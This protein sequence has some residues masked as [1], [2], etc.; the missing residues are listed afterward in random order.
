MKKSKGKRKYSTSILSRLLVPMLF[1]FVLQAA[2]MMAMFL[3]SDILKKSGENAYGVLSEKVLNRKLIIENEMTNRWTKVSDLHDRV[4]DVVKK[5]L[6]VN[7]IK[8]YDLAAKPEVQNRILDE[9]LPYLL[10]VIRRNYVTGVF[11]VLDAPSP[12]IKNTEFS[13]PGLYIRTD[14]PSSY[15]STNEDIVISRGP[16]DVI[17][18]HKIALGIDWLPF[19]TIAPKSS[20][21]SYRYFNAPIAAALKYPKEPSKNSAFWNTL[22]KLDSLS[23]EVITYSI[24]LMDDKGNIYGVIGID[25][26]AGYIQSFLNFDELDNTKKGMYCMAVRDL[27]GKNRSFDPIVF[28]S[29]ATNLNVDHIPSFEAEKTE[30]AN[31]YTVDKSSIFAERYCLAVEPFHLYQRNGMYE[32]QEWVL[33]GLAPESRILSFSQTLKKIFWQSVLV[34]GFL[35]LAGSYL[36]SKH[37]SSMF[38]KVVHKLQNSDPRKRVTIE[39]MNISE[40]DTLITA[41]EKLSAS[42]FNAASRVSTIIERLQVPIGVFE[43]NILMG[44]VFCNSI[45]FK[46]F[47]IENYTGDSVLKTDEFYKLL[48]HYE[49]YINTKD[50]EKTIYAIPTGTHGMVRWIRFMQ[51]KENDRTLGMAVDITKEVQD[52]KKLELQMNY[53]ELTGLYNRSAFDRKIT[54]VFKQKHLG[55]CALVMWDLDN[56]KYLNDSFGHAYGDTHLMSFGKKLAMLQQDRCLVCRR[57]GDEFYTF[58]YTFSTSDEIKLILT[59]FWKDIQETSIKLPNGENSK[60]RVS[61]GL[62]WYPYDADNQADLVRYAD[63][64]MY[65]VKHSFKGSLHEFNL[66]VYK[67]NYIMIYGTEALNQM[68]E[69]NLIEYAMQPIVIAGT[70][71]IYGYEMLMRS[72]HPDFKNPEDILRLA[73]AQSK[74][75]KLEELTFF[76]AMETFVQKIEKGEISK[77]AKIFLNTISSQVLS[78]A[79]FFD[80]EERFKPYLSNIVMEI[81]ESEPLNTNFYDIKNERIRNWN[82]MIAI[83]DFG[84]GYSNESS[85]LFLSP[86]LVKIDMSI[87]R[88]VHK[89]LDKQNVLE[90]LVSY[91]KKR[92]IIILAEGVETID[93]IDVLLRFGVDLFQGYFFAKPS[94]DIVPISEEKIRELNRIYSLY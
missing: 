18:K 58:F 84:S 64:A 1:V 32:N 68:L 51:M 86:N 54:E 77:H 59:A 80:F 85:L 76:G 35:F 40:I 5:E 67:K 22:F 31:V 56:L 57:S 42:V 88:D 81:T 78:D 61:A 94:F 15:S 69:R 37:I 30:Y 62:A 8:I 23:D 53:D 24:P 28:N 29:I 74:L 34:S 36:S 66:D 79:K 9:V 91:A 13:Y 55:I 20:D 47:N 17:Q 52:R 41:I 87:V 14:A 93:E 70:G 48:N 50:D 19:F 83:D 44:T 39:K 26:T 2:V 21:T 16:S 60:L 27:N 75:H 6:S 25:L 63:F 46:L 45:W 33:I 11:V 90:N 43:H 3:N 71:D 73:K 92:D 38:T 82:A 10:Y 65:D 4:I 12:L 89:S 49:Y 7:G 72:S